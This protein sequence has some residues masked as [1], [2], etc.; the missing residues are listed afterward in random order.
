MDGD[1][2]ERVAAAIYRAQKP[3]VSWSRATALTQSRRRAEAR[4]ALA[5]AEPAIRE[6]CATK[7]EAMERAHRDAL[8]GIPHTP[9]YA[10]ALRDGA[11]AIR[12]ARGGA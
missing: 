3:P 1:L 5:V 12:S 2:V 6:A 7:L 11:A 4:A 9:D 10:I 8:I